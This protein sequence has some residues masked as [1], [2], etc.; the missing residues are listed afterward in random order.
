MKTT[1]ALILIA[2]MN[3]VNFKRENLKPIFVIVEEVYLGSIVV[4]YNIYF[5]E[6]FLQDMYMYK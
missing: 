2:E 3:T 5:F 6:R 1:W 4:Q